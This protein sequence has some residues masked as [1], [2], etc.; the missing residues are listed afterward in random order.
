MPEY[1]VLCIG[2]AIVDII[3][4]CD[5][6][7]LVD[8]GIIKGAM[9]LIDAERAELLYSTHG[10]GDRGLGRLRRQHGGGHCR[11][12]AGA[13][14]IS[15][16]SPDDHL[17]RHLSATT[18]APRA[19]PSTPAP[20]DGHAA[21][22]A[23]DDLR[24]AGRRALDEH[25][26]RRL[27]RTR[28]GGRRGR[29]GRRAAKVT[30][31]EGYLW[32]PPRA[33]EAIRLPPRSRMP[34]GRECR[35][36]AVGPLLRRPLSRRIPRPDALG[37]GRHRLRQRGGAEVALPDLV[38]RNGAR[39]AARNDCTL[40]AV[41]RSRK[42]LR[43]RQ[44]ARRRSRLPAIEIDELVD[45]TGAGDLYAAGFLFGYTHGQE[46]RGLRPGSGR[47][48]PGSSSSRSARARWRA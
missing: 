41:T 35:D 48:P 25:L 19:W 7:F 42:G 5:D 26:S 2:N 32:D 23:L 31:F 14:P 15:A 36:D 33:K 27:R 20:L 40:A 46:P 21:D 44:R 38:L 6:D 13:P 11:A 39:R 3:A 34:H 37:H 45:T 8:N 10:P 28:P 47:W 9:N 4:R 22:G 16:R 24:H 30:Y 1:D 43:R 29:Q 12:S 18:S 17:G